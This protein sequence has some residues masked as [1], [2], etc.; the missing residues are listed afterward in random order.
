M[1]TENITV[2]GEIVEALPNSRF[3]V[4]LHGGKMEQIDIDNRTITTAFISQPIGKSVIAHLAGKMRKHRIKT[5]VGD[6]VQ[7]EI[8]PYDLDKGRIV[9]RFNRDA[10]FVEALESSLSDFDE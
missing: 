5:L 2:F 1:K 4:E 9:K 6:K 10:D 7:V 3:D 8:S